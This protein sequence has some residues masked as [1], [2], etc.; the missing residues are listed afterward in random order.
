MTIEIEE[1]LSNKIKIV[2]NE[3]QE[4]QRQKERERSIETSNEK[5]NELNKFLK[6]CELNFKNEISNLLQ[7]SIINQN[8]T[9]QSS[10]DDENLGDGFCKATDEDQNIVK[11]KWEKGDKHSDGSSGNGKSK[12]NKD[13]EGEDDAVEVF[14]KPQKQQ[15]PKKQ[16][17]GLIV[18]M[19]D[20]K[21]RPDFVKPDEYGEYEEPVTDKYLKSDGLILINA[22]NPIIAKSRAHQKFQHIFN[23]RVANYVLLVVAQFQTQR[24]LDLQPED[25]RDEPMNVFR[26]RYFKL[27]RDLRDDKE[28]DYYNEEAETIS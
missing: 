23:E 8:D 16:K 4:T 1:F 20:D 15:E 24:E 17:R 5:I 27:Q 21:D 13:T 3:I 11:G 18:M 14:D 9:D 6:K 19:T 26:Q 2:I 28:I 25:E 10:I 7:P 12:F 22:N